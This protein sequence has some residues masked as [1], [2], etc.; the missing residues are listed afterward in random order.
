MSFVRRVSSWKVCLAHHDTVPF[1]T[2]HI[3]NMTLRSKAS[4]NKF[5]KCPLLI[6]WTSMP[7]CSQSFDLKRAVSLVGVFCCFQRVFFLYKYSTVYEHD[8]PVLLCNLSN[9]GRRW[10]F[11]KIWIQLFRG[12]A[13]RICDIL[14]TP[15]FE[16]LRVRHISFSGSFFDHAGLPMHDAGSVTNIGHPTQHAL[17]RKNRN[18]GILK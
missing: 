10:V 5:R 7:R 14:P 6:K 3:P 11:W 1:M 17:S 16:D 13:P 18:I 8:L 2:I 15:R 12:C 4:T 9:S